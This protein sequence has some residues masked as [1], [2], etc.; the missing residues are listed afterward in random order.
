L[1]HWDPDYNPDKPNEIIQTKIPQGVRR[2]ILDFFDGDFKYSKETY[3]QNL[4]ALTLFGIK[5]RELISTEASQVAELILR[6]TE[7]DIK[8]AETLV[9]NNPSLLHRQAQVQ[10]FLG[11]WIRGTLLQIAVMTGDV[12]LEP[13]IT[14]KEDRGIAERLT[15]AANLSSLQVKEQLAEILTS[16]KAKRINEEKNQRV[17]QAIQR[18]GEGILKV[19]REYQGNN[20]EDFQRRCQ[21]CIDQ[22]EEALTPNPKEVITS[23]YVFDLK[24]LQDAVDW[25]RTKLS[26]RSQPQPNIDHFGFRGDEWWNVAGRVFWVNGIG[27]LQ[28]LL[29]RRDRQ[30]MQQPRYGGSLT[31]IPSRSLIIP[32]E[33][34]DCFGSLFSQLGR[35]FYLGHRG[36]GCLNI[37]DGYYGSYLWSPFLKRYVVHKKNSISMLTRSVKFAHLIESIDGEIASFHLAKS[38]FTM[39][40]GKKALLVQDALNRALAHDVQFNSDDDFLDF[41]MAGHLSVKEALNCPRKNFMQ[42]PLW[43]STDVWQRV[44]TIAKKR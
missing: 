38:F 19:K 27:K 22:L 31:R 16:E 42:T 17:L 21:S 2:M 5:H 36:L 28:K 25:F 34:A 35:D 10:D 23:G 7:G 24:I 4:Q 9:K 1:H 13:G 6:G 30:L 8:K 18:F 44:Q 39:G 26:E 15:L 14:N 43:G 20:F 33:S 12:D 3:A 41:K 40:M 11:R 37:E 29:S 32:E